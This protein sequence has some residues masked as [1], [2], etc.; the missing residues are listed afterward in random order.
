MTDY[1]KLFEDIKESEK[2]AT[3][4]WLRLTP[5]RHTLTFKSEL[6]DPFRND[7][8]SD[9]KREVFQVNV[10][11]EENGK[12]YRWSITKGKTQNSL[13]G[14]VVEFAKLSGGLKDKTINLLVTGEGKDRRYMINELIDLKQKGNA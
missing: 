3:G 5:G 10:D 6:G 11:V 9:A 12:T 4:D 14:Q 7:V 8:L 2:N 1:N 13:Y